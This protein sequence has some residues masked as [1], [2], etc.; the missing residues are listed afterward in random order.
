MQRLI[1]SWY[2]I[3]HHF[4]ENLK[5]NKFSIYHECP[6]SFLLR[7]KARFSNRYCFNL[8]ILQAISLNSGGGTIWSLNDTAQTRNTG[9]S[10]VDFH[11]ESEDFKST[12]AKV[13]QKRYSHFVSHIIQQHKQNGQAFLIPDDRENPI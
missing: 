12:N 7:K 8:T 6:Q 9:S 3:W 4:T 5:I 13:F 11:G 10:F 2:R 1:A